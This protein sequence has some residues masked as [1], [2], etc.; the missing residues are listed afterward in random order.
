MTI[1]ALACVSA[2]AAIVTASS[3]PAAPTSLTARATSS[4]AIA[5]TWVDGDTTITGFSIERSL[6]SNNGFSEIARTGNVRSYQDSG[7]AR[8]TTYYYRMR[9]MRNGDF[10]TRS[11]VA[12]ATTMSDAI[13]PTVPSGVSASATSCSQVTIRWNASTDTGG[14]GL[15]AYKLFRND[16]YLKSVAATTLST[17]DASLAAS[18]TYRYAVSAIDGAGNESA[19]SAAV[20]V[21]LPGCTVAAATATPKPTITPTRTGALPTPTPTVTATPD[22]VPPSVPGTLSLSASG[23]TQLNLAWGTSTD[24]GSG[25]SG[26]IVYKNGSFYKRIY[27]PTHALSD[28]AVIGSTTYSYFVRAIDDVGN[29]SAP[30]NTASATTCNQPPIAAA[31]PDESAAPGTAVTLNGSGSSDPDGSIASYAWTFGDGTGASGAVVNHAY[32]AAGNYTATLTVTDTFGA[33]ASDSASVAVANPVTG[34]P[35]SAVWRQARGGASSTLPSA[36]A[37]DSAGNVV[38]VGTFYGSTDLGTGVLTSAGVGDIFLAKY[39]PAGAPLWARRYGGTGND[40]GYGVAIDRRAN[41]DGAGG[42]NC[43]VLTGAIGGTADLGRGPLVSA[44]A[45]DIVV[46]RYTA[47]GT[48]LWTQRYGDAQDD[49]G[50]AVAIDPAGNV[51]VTGYYTIS[52]DFGAG[53]LYSPYY[54]ADTFV[55]KLAPSG[56]LA[57]AR[58]FWSGSL[59]VGRAIAV[60]ATGDVVV[61]GYN[62]GSLDVGLGARLSRGA[63]DVYVTKLAGADGHALWFKGFGGAMSDIAYGVVVDGAGDVAVA[64]TSQSSADVG[65]GIITAAGT[66]VFVTKLAGATGAPSWSRRCTGTYTDTRRANALSVDAANNLI[67]GGFFQGTMSCSG[68][69]AITSAVNGFSDAFVAKLG[70]TGAPMWT[71][72]YGGDGSDGAAAV[73]TDPT[74]AEVLL[75][76]SFQYSVDFGGGTLRSTGTD[77]LFLL[78]LTP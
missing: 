7:L 72:G 50:Y 14:S 64:G 36:T 63:E 32:A 9:A 44:G 34:T 76:G 39:S 29:M 52:T 57:W 56:A 75:T 21:T 31:G 11:N 60:S 5:L 13:A 70:S 20:S 4:S 58:N 78:K 74:T 45:S 15:S 2:P 54:D 41:C 23:C 25:L 51:L 33:R 42:T 38:V 61:A 12:G 1:L 17:T 40:R 69:T 47:A 67:L 16:V 24:V 22:I 8:A 35:G 6:N 26:Y 49:V 73:T 66:D 30:T 10:S 37:V 55:L 27:A 46:A 3:G 28:T 65:G 43:I 77:M 59:D 18:A 19:R 71:K 53:R 62:M 48:P 68:A